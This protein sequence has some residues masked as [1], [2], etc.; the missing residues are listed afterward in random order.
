MTIAGKTFT[1]SQ[2]GKE[3]ASFDGTWTGRATS[4]TPFDK[5]GD[6]CGSADFTLV[7]NNNQITGT[8][9]DSWGESYSLSGNVTSDGGITYVMGKGSAGNVGN[10]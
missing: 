10:S 6:D 4:T 2:A 3:A 9:I 7:V 5:Y 8:G 1:V